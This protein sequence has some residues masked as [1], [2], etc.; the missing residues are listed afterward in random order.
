[1][2]ARIARCAVFIFR[3]R[4]RDIWRP[5]PNFATSGD[6][7]FNNNNNNN[8]SDRTNLN[9]KPKIAIR[10]NENGTCMLIDVAISVD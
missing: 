2:L 3:R 1:M 10:D 5:Q 4:P 8:N 7:Q 6:K 9:N